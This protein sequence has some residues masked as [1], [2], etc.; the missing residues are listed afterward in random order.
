M[1]DPFNIHLNVAAM[2]FARDLWPHGF[3]VDRYGAAETLEALAFQ[4]TH[5]GQITV[6][7]AHCETT[8]FADPEVN[9]NF[10]AW[11]DWAHWRYSLGFDLAGERA[12]AMVQAAQVCRRFGPD[13][14]M[15]ALLFCEVIGQS[16]HYAAHGEFP[17]DQVEF[18]HTYLPFFQPMAADFANLDAAGGL[19]DRQAIRVASLMG[20]AERVIR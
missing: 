9:V 5:D 11:H 4:V 10:R 15:L 12:A 16:E 14:D 20:R 13:G 19:T 7:D 6:S 1:R 3:K 18:T 2:T 17:R 8:I